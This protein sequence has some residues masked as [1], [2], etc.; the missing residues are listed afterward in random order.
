MPAVKAILLLV[1]SVIVKQLIGRSVELS[2]GSA[3]V[4]K[5]TKLREF[6]VS[7]PSKTTSKSAIML[8]LATSAKAYKADSSSRCNTINVSSS[9]CMFPRK[10][11]SRLSSSSPN[12]LGLSTGL[13]R[14]HSRSCVRPRS[15]PAPFAAS[16]TPS[17]YSTKRSDRLYVTTV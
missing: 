8:L 4:S 3:Q 1:E 7:T 10:S 16:V 13:W 5:G 11:V 2:T 9:L 6:Y 12:T 17:V 15:L 14:A